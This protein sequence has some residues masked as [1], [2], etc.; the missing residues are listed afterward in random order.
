[1]KDE[2]TQDQQAPQ[3]KLDVQ[4]FLRVRNR[5]M[6][7]VLFLGIAIYSFAYVSDSIKKKQLE[8]D[9]SRFVVD[10]NHASHAELNLLPGVGPKLA[11]EILNLRASQGGFSSVDEISKIRGIKG[12]RFAAL[13]KYLVVSAD[14]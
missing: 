14:R 12:A 11:D 8:F 7:I 10:L 2:S 6:A 1:M 5:S 4:E 3:P 13:K 9:T